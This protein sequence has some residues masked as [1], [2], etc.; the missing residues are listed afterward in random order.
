MI[1]FCHKYAFNSYY[2]GIPEY[3]CLESPED[4]KEKIEFLEANPDEYLKLWNQCQAMLKDE[5]FSGEFFNNMLL[6]ELG[7]V[8][9]NEVAELRKL[10]TEKTYNMS[11]IFG[12]SASSTKKISNI[13]PL[14]R[15][16]HSHKAIKVLSC[17]WTLSNTRC[18]RPPRFSVRRPP[19]TRC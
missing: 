10:T 16:N 17:V 15:T 9:P 1:P 13:T 2:D 4:F 6:D 12:T 19:N 18:R 8:F 3:L 11:C 5:Y 14:C 7:E